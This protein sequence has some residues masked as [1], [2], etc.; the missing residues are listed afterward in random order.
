MK[1]FKL[2]DIEAFNMLYERYSGKLFRYIR[3]RVSDNET[4]REIFQDTFLKLSA[5]RSSY[6]EDFLFAPWLFCIARNVLIDSLRKARLNQKNLNNFA[7]A[8][9]AAIVQDTHSDFDELIKSLTV[10]EQKILSLKFKEDLTFEKI[11]QYLGMS[12]ANIRKI[13]SRALKHLKGSGL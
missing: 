10:R 11:S 6:K 4:C 2:G 9:N 3:K 8:A 5:S 13:A 7:I 12:P 1:T